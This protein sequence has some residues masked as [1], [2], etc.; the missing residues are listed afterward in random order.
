[1][2]WGIITLTKNALLLAKEIK[3]RKIE[4]VIYTKE[5]YNNGVFKNT[6]GEFENI[7]G[8]FGSFV[9][10]VFNKH[11]VLVFIMAAGIVVRS[12]AHLLTDKTNDPGVLVVDEKGRFVI[13]LLS[14]H[15]GGAN[16]ACLELAGILNAQPV[17][18]TASDLNDRL[19]VDMLAKE[20]GLI[21]DDMGMAKTIT[22]MIVNEEK[23]ALISDAAMSIPPYLDSKESEAEGI[24]YIGNKKRIF[25]KPAVRLIPKN[26]TLGIGCRKNIPP[27]QV[28]GF[29]EETLNEL[30]IDE[31]SI[32][33]IGTIE[34][35]KDE[36]GIIKTSEH[37]ACPLR[38]MSK[39][40]INEVEEKFSKS[41]FVKSITGAAN[42][43][44]SC[45]YLASDKQGKF[46]VQ[47]KISAGITL[48]VF[49]E[50][51]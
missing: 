23:V 2:S 6:T 45:A 24:I 26:I 20:H 12:I 41:E 32:K 19:S 9:K 3:K 16:A 42:V 18:T 21:I 39:E 5:K 51:L 47:K 1:M 10:I 29:V 13:S 22:V 11:E 17:I 8:D 38:L 48:S 25:S 34:L 50:E 28:I 14:G 30:N 27:K 44:E 4:C 31:R 36:E 43:S 37:F 15:I 46:L 7:T 49:E 40:N 33:A 35:K